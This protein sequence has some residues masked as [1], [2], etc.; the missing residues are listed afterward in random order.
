MGVYVKVN[1]HG[2]AKILNH[3]EIQT[4]F[5]DGLTNLRDRVLFAVCLFTAARINEACT[6]HKIIEIA[7]ILIEID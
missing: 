5:N 3:N 1:R 2:K 6:L 7:F 4:L